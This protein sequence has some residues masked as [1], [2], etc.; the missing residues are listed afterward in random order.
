MIVSEVRRSP[1]PTRGRYLLLIVV[2]LLGGASA[3]VPTHHLLLGQR[4]KIE[5]QACLAH[6]AAAVPHDPL[7]RSRL[8][9]VCRAPI[10]HRLALFAVG[11]AVLMLAVALLLTWLLPHLL[12]RRM[13]ERRPAPEALSVRAAAIASQLAVRRAPAVELGPWLLRQPF[14]VRAEGATR[15]VLP[16]GLNR[17]TTDQVDAVLRH[18]TAHVAAG[19][20]TLVWLTRSL[21]WAL[22]ML[23]AVPVAIAVTRGEITDAFWLD[24]LARAALL[25]F[26]GYLLVRGIMRDREHEADTH[27]A[28]AG[29]APALEE[30]FTTARPPRPGRLRGLLAMHPS[31]ARRLAVLHD[32]DRLRGMSGP[33]E[34]VASGLAVSV[35]SFGTT[36]L[37][38]GLLGTPFAVYA[39]GVAGLAAGALLAATWGLALWSRPGPRP[40]VGAT[41]GLAAGAAAGLRLGMDPAALAANQGVG[42]W[43]LYVL[44]PLAVAGAGGCVLA[45][46]AVPAGFGPLSPASAAAPD[47]P[48]PGRAAGAD[49]RW[50][51]MAWVVGTVMFAGGLWI[52]AGAAELV[53]LRT[54]A[55]VGDPIGVFWLIGFTSG[56]IVP[57]AV[58]MA[59]LAVVVAVRLGRR[60]AGPVFGAGLIVGG[61]AFAVRWLVPTSEDGAYESAALDWWTAAAA[62]CTVVLALLFRR[63]AT[64]LGEAMLAAPV[65]ALT[66]SAGVLLRFLGDWDDPVA[67][68]GVYFSRPL[69]MIVLVTLAVAVLAGLLPAREAPSG[70][71]FRWSV[72]VLA[73]LTGLVVLGLLLADGYFLVPAR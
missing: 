73:V 48:S 28:A 49:W 39:A 17:R 47:R 46:A 16:P 42:N 26:G 22:P 9:D 55:G 31:P 64:G 4:W 19:D 12:L 32:P 14:T 2:L 45:L 8:I 63:G 11:G 13:G 40:P 5:T 58:A 10:E 65:A 34:A 60:R 59:A 54:A 70:R 71:R 24:Y 33:T 61:T 53:P 15:I 25:W 21:F 20:V 50:W 38:W 37:G 67:A 68:A 35:W 30:L 41:L 29:S 18:E 72:A 1:S 69:A 23:L 27:A 62:G 7:L 66:V 36:L 6:A 56:W 52:G 3:G 51:P 44:L 57:A 43:W